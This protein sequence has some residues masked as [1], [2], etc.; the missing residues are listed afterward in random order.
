MSKNLKSSWEEQ[1]GAFLGKNPRAKIGDAG[2]A[3]QAYLSERAVTNVRAIKRDLEFAKIVQE[4]ENEGSDPQILEQDMELARKLQDEEKSLADPQTLRRDLALAKKLQDEE[5][6]QSFHEENEGNELVD[7]RQCETDLELAFKLQDHEKAMEE[8]AI[9]LARS[10]QTRG[11]PRPKRRSASNMLPAPG[12]NGT[13]CATCKQPA[14]YYVQVLGNIYHPECFICMGC[15]EVIKADEPIACHVGENGEQNPLHRRCYAELFGMKCIVCTESIPMDSEG[16]IS[17]VKHPFFSNEHMCPKHADE[18]RRRC[19]GCY[20]YEPKIGGFAD[21]GDGNRCVCLACCRTVV[22]DSADAKPLW[23]K[24]I[25]FFEHG[26]KLP[27]WKGMSD[28]PI[29]IVSHDALNEQ[30]GGSAHSGA[31]HLMTRGLCLSEHQCGHQFEIPSMRFNTINGSFIPNDE[32]SRGHTLFQIPD[33]LTSHPESSVTAIL[34]LSGLPVD[35]TASILAHEATHA[36]IKLNPNFTIKKPIPKLV[37]EGCCQLVAMLLLNDGL[38]PTS[39][40]S[41]DGEPS[42]DRLRQFFKFSIETDTNEI[43]GEGYRLAAKTYASIGIEAL[44]NHVV[45]YQEIPVV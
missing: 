39:K 30:L 29:L 14:R 12:D 42:D 38:G 13:V 8:E 7:P 4:K 43:Y 40:D 35:L 10:G 33:A 17:F 6:L 41:I 32:E 15:H 44:L 20:R 2:I 5:K 22:V 23:D 16:K 37:E 11:S 1:D 3:V 36:W 25:H 28:V 9:I 31:A 34:C 24:V 45:C 26:L 19:T 21:L 18:N 27:I